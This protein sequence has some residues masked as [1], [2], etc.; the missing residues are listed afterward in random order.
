MTKA[1]E[2]GPEVPPG[3]WDALLRGEHGDPFAMLG[4]HPDAQGRWWISAFLPGAVS[5]DVLSPGGERVLATLNCED[6]RGLFTARVPRV[7]KRPDYRLRIEW[8]SGQRSAALDD[9]YRHLPLLGATD[10]WLLAEGTEQR[11]YEKLGAHVCSIDGVDGTMFAVWAPHARRVSVVGDW[12]AWDARRHVMRLRREAGVWEIFVPAVAAGARYKFAILDMHGAH[13]PWRADPYARQAEL[14]PATAS[15]VAATLPACAPNTRTLRQD[16]PM[17]VYEVHV[18]S[19]RRASAESNRWPSWDELADTLIPY[20]QDLGFTHLELMPIAEH[21]FDGSWGYQPIGLY[22]PTARCGDPAGLLRFIA[23]CH[24]ADVGVIL[25]WVPGHFPADLH[26][27]ARFDGSHLY[28]HADPR[29][30]SHP[31]WGTL[32]YNYGRFEVRDFLIGN[33]RY[34]IERFGIDGLRVDAVASMIYRDYS[35]A[36]GEWIPNVHGGRENLEAIAF[37]KRMNEELGADYPQALTIAEESTSWPG[38]SQPTSSGGLGFHYKWNMG[39]MNDV[40]RYFAR[41]P[42]YRRHHQNELTFGLLYAFNEHFILPLSHDEV[43]HGKGSLLNKMPGDRWQRFANLRLLLAFMYAHPGR[44]LLFMGGEFGQEREWNHDQSLDW[45]LLDDAAHRGVQHLVR[46]LNERYRRLPALHARDS[47][48]AGFEW[49]SH[50]EHDTS[51]LAFMRYGHHSHERLVAVFNFTPVVRHAYRLGVPA[52]GAWH[53]CLNSDSGHYGGSNLGNHGAR[54]LADAIAA[55]GRSHS[56][57]L[58]LPPLGALF[59]HWTD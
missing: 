12:N 22:A 23:R 10:L 41:D 35:R 58:D 25:D 30:G 24:A 8:S 16:M 46:D 47:E 14:R 5:V 42:V 51:V 55:H 40:L 50:D 32:I 17:A 1:S 9:P 56:L 19:W 11:P 59:L 57:L 15:V 34:W 49:L 31:D 48:A 39:W 38:V 36:A 3:A 43:V 33:A 53:E 52:D 6:S 44:K 13:E 18:G 27:L 4:P 54:L 45:H 7:H 28:E 21:P 29:E 26:G 2:C 37:L 20:A